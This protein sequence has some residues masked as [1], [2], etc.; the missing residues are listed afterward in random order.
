MLCLTAYSAQ[1]INSVFQG[2]R[3]SVL[4]DAVEG[5][6]LIN[7]YSQKSVSRISD[8]FIYI[9]SL[10]CLIKPMFHENNGISCYMR[11]SMLVPLAMG[12]ILEETLVP[13]CSFRVFAS[14]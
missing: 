13:T 1:K 3:S 11:I 2:H 9:P 6:D 8:F 7:E 5:W 4:P 10:V 14:L 12:D